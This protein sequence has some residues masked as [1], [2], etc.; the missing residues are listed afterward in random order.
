M[1]TPSIFRSGLIAS[2]TTEILPYHMR[3]K[4]YT[5]M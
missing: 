2:Y 5:V 4:G 3:A 1:L